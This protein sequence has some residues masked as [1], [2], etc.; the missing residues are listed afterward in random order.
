MDIKDENRVLNEIG[1]QATK[2]DTEEH[3]DLEYAEIEIRLEG[4]AKRANADFPRDRLYNSVKLEI[5]RRNKRRRDLYRGLSIAACIMICLSVGLFALINDGSFSP[6]GTLDPTASPAKDL[7]TP[8]NMTEP[9]VTAGV[10][11]TPLVDDP[12]VSAKD[13]GNMVSLSSATAV[14]LEGF[15]SV[16]SMSYSLGSIT[17]PTEKKMVPER[18]L[19]KGWR[20]VAEKNADASFIVAYNDK[21]EKCYEAALLKSRGVLDMD[22]GECLIDTSDGAKIAIWRIQEDVCMYV[23]CMGISNDDLLCALKSFVGESV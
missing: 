1:E 9:M 17:P 2:A 21:N 19:E 22:I 7:P 23:R 13:P 5:V 18:V 8:T 15:N 20:V 4:A 12:D 3:H 16:S 10:T 11:S 6:I 14:S